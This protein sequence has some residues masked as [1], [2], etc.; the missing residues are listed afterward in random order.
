MPEKKYETQEELFHV[1]PPSHETGA[2]ER[3]VIELLAEL[4]SG[5]A[6][7]GIY[8][9]KGN[10]LLTLARGV[11]Q[12]MRERKISVATSQLLK[13]LYDGITEMPEPPRH[14]SADTYDTLRAVIEY[15]TEQAIT[16]PEESSIHEPDY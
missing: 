14:N 13:Q 9:A 7:T 8:R 11:D 12:G 5:G 4:D 1:P 16:R 2:N 3:T 15:M 10:V 6:L